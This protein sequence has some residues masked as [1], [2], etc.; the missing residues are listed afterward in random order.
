M[1]HISS[2]QPTRTWRVIHQLRPVALGVIAAA[3]MVACGGG[4]SGSTNGNSGT[5]NMAVRITDGPDIGADHVWVTIEKVAV[6]SSDT[7]DNNSNGWISTTL[8]NPVTVDLNSLANG[9]LTSVLANLTLPTGTY[10]Q[11]RLILAG[12]DEALTNSAVN[13]GLRYNDEVDYTDSHGNSQAAPLEIAQAKQG[14]SLHGTFNVAENTTLNLA[15]EFDAGNDIIPF[16]SADHTAFTMVPVLKYFDLAASGAIIGKVDTSACASLATN[17]CANVV[18]K[19]ET[20]SSDGTV[21]AVKRWT[22][23]ESDGTFVLYPV[24][25]SDQ[26]YDVVVHG[27]NA[28]TIV[29]RSVP[30][31]AGSTPDSG[32]TT[33]SANPL[34]I[35]SAVSYPVNWASSPQ[36]TGVTGRFYQT[37]GAALPYEVST[38]RLDP[39]SGKFMV[40]QMLTAGDTMVGDYVAGGDPSL[41][42]MTP[43]EG[44]GAYT[45]MLDGPALARTS[46]GTVAATGDGST[47]MITTPTMTVSK[48]VAGFGSIGGMIAQTTA[49]KYDS[50]YVVVTRGGMIV[51]TMDIS[52]ILQAN[53]GMGGSY[54]IDHLPAG[55]TT[56]PL[57]KDGN[58]KGIYY[59]YLRV[60]NSADTAH[61]TLVPVD[62]S[63]DLDTTNN[64]TLNVTIP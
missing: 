21:H 52:A 31:T 9:S 23:V 5:G 10:R 38:K 33:V 6:H 26:A 3:A 2:R 11:I 24:P 14:I 13:A 4:S 36:P 1:S 40:D 62:G 54:A 18:A 17:P 32:A 30:I 43:A 8:A 12:S 7:A 39:F 49:G 46:A 37:L 58:G 25:L 28:Q 50:G 61:V 27:D 53:G 47:A 19:A 57:G 41:S 55:S 20:T 34:A 64:A 16:R 51:N 59:A 22:T 45:A 56:V 29:V 42:A 35:A 15:I 60:W 44:S 48:N 63:A